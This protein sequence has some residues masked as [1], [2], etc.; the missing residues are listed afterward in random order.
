LLWKNIL[1]SNRCCTIWFRGSLPWHQ[2][3]LWVPMIFIASGLIITLLN[4]ISAAMAAWFD[5]I[6]EPLWWGWG[7]LRNS[8]AQN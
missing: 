3:L 8:A 4:P 1:C 7:S 5:W 2:Y 6:P